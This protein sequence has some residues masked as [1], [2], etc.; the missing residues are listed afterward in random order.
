M[1]CEAEFNGK[2]S[3]GTAQL[4]TDHLVFRGDFRI[5][6]PLK[7]VRSARAVEGVLRISFS[8]GEA[9]FRLGSRAEKW[10][11]NIRSPKS[12]LDKLGVK[13][14]S[15]VSVLGVKDDGFLNDLRSR[16]TNVSLGRLR[17]SSDIVFLAAEA[18]RDLRR[19]E[20]IEPYI[21]RNGAVWVV[22]PKGRPEI[23]DV[24][25]IQAGVAVGLVDTKVVRFSHSHTALKF[26]IPV[27]RR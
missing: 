25:V 15:L 4:E 23:R 3:E 27:A 22:S 26:V 6:I 2:W 14:D 8:G 20:R 9:A 13:S 7:D 21:Q 18:P 24:V 1:R 17:K 5:S 10:A 16:T 19:L 12:L 11:E